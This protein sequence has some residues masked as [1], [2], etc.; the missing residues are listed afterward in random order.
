MTNFRLVNGAL[1]LYQKPGTGVLSANI[2]TQRELQ[3]L[4]PRES[5]A[6]FQSHIKGSASSTKALLRKRQ[7]DVFTF[8]CPD[9]TGK[10]PS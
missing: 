8:K 6:L 10:D 9:D 1:F 2:G 3:G 4:L 5:N 7:A